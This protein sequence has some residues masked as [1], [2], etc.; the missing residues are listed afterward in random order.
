MLTL[1]A[2]VADQTN[3]ET[4]TVFK[5]RKLFRLTIILIVIL[6]L[7][8]IAIF[9][10]VI[11]WLTGTLFPIAETPQP[12]T[13]PTVVEP[14][15]PIE[16]SPPENTIIFSEEELQSILDRLSDMVNQSGAA[17]VEYMRVKLVKDK[18]LL[19]AKG[20]AE[21]YHAETE[22]LEIWFEGKTVFASGEVSAFG[23]SPTLTAEAEINCE[24]GKPSVEV[25][26]FKLGG[27]PLHVLG[28][29]KDKISGLI[30]GAIEATGIEAPVDLDSIR[31]EDGKL[32]VVYKEQGLQE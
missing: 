12:T 7:V 13:P 27:L 31:I 6:A 3:W 11:P 30:N 28:L 4:V 5:R 18:M 1:W 22:D 17:R 10:P 29:P 21:G 14:P 24:S 2:G 32:I 23:L 8:V 19:S 26:E 25:S 9:T 20:E 15:P 16:I